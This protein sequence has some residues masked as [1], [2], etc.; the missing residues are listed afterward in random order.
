MLHVSALETQGAAD[1]TGRG[2]SLK[3]QFRVPHLAQPRTVRE[4][5]TGSVLY[6]HLLNFDMAMALSLGSGT[7][8]SCQTTRLHRD[9]LEAWIRAHDMS[10]S[11]V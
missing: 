9:G 1:L 6:G 5:F 8:C 7:L 2:Y 10:F 11:M 3:T 4:G